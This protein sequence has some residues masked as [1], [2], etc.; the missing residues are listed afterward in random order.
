[1]SSEHAPSGDVVLET[2][3]NFR[4]VAGPGYALAG[5]GTMT[6]GL[7]YRGPA[8]TCGDA[9]IATLAALGLRRVVDLRTTD[10]IARQPDLLPAGV[11]QVEVDVLA[12]HTSAVTVLNAHT[13][14]AESAREEMRDT[15]LG[16]VR[17]A[18]EPCAFGRVLRALATSPGPAV[19]H[20]TA[21]KDRTGWTAALLQMLAGVSDDDV[22]ADYLRTNELSVDFVT[23]I[24]GFVEQEMPEQVEVM[25]VLLHVEPAYLEA[26]L[27]AMRTDH[28]DVRSYLLGACG[29]EETLLDE[30]TERL[31]E[32]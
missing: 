18:E 23:S 16:F 17:G 28:G 32:G 21:G 24:R 10:E 3:H 15:Y 2:V 19:V 11:E 20:C 22:M 7:Y 31:R 9:D 8:L 12:G 26:A 13:H 27:G 14:T 5:G 29:L 6:R 1:M 30:L 25:D 4:D